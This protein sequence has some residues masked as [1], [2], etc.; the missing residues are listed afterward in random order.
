MPSRIP[1]HRRAQPPPRQRSPTSPK[2]D[3]RFTSIFVEPVYSDP[4]VTEAYEE[5]WEQERATFARRRRGQ[6]S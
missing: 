2:P 5:E 6:R 4:A 1:E 3:Y